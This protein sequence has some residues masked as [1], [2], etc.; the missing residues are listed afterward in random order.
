M[1]SSTKFTVLTY[2]TSGNLGVIVCTTD[3][4]TITVN[5]FQN[6][7]STT[8]YLRGASFF[9]INS[10]LIGICLSDDNSYYSYATTINIGTT[11]ASLNSS[12]TIQVPGALGSDLSYI[13]AGTITLGS[14]YLVTVIDNT[15]TATEVGYFINYAASSGKKLN[16]TTI[17]KWNGIT[18]SKINSI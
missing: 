18:P 10:S 5:S 14:Q 3:N 16:G 9:N 6:L 1:L 7:F 12:D 17:S 2:D 15:S 4:S 8:Y 13:T 11:T